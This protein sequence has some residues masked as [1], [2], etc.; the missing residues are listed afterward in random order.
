[1]FFIVAVLK[2]RQISQQKIGGGDLEI[3]RKSFLIEISNK[4]ISLILKR[5]GNYPQWKAI[6]AKLNFV[7]YVFL[8]I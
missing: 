2:F 8:I 6:F 3:F 7:T 4:F 1:M 5:S